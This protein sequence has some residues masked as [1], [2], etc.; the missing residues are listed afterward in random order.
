MAHSHATKAQ[1][2]EIVNQLGNGRIGSKLAQALIEGRVEI[3][4][5]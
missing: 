2:I 1:I 4:A 3:K 5:L